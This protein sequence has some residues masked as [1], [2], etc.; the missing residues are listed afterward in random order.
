[1]TTIFLNRFCVWTSLSKLGFTLCCY[2]FYCSTHMC[3][4]EVDRLCPEVLSWKRLIETDVLIMK[5]KVEIRGRCGFTSIKEDV[6]YNKG[7]RDEH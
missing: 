2:Y 5:D 1:M 7:R 4:T 6:W 3:Y